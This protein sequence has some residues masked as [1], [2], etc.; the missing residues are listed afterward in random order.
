MGSTT[1]IEPTKEY[2]WGGECGESKRKFKPHHLHFSVLP[3]QNIKTCKRILKKKRYKKT[4]YFT[5]IKDPIPST[6]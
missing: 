6:Q 4:N 2:G 3:E 5:Y 1:M